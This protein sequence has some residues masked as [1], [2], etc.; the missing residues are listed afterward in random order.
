MDTEGTPT[1]PCFLPSPS[2]TCLCGL[3]V[4]LRDP[5]EPPRASQSVR[6]QVGK[7]VGGGSTAEASGH[8]PGLVSPPR[9]QATETPTRSPESAACLQPRSWL[10]LH[11]PAAL[12]P[13]G[14]GQ[15]TE[16]PE[17][18][19]SS[20]GVCAAFPGGL[21]SGLVVGGGGSSLSFSPHLALFLPGLWA[22]AAC[23]R[24]AFPL[25]AVRL[26]AS[27]AQP[28][29]CWSSHSHLPRPVYCL[30]YLPGQQFCL[31]RLP[32]PGDPAG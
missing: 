18:G 10:W 14:T 31:P 26:E 12:S 25:L 32:L 17:V 2:L 4:L 5:L 8:L 3:R 9:G 6:A 29:L 21:S 13:G 15:E 7:A 28:G 16:A 20:G 30:I 27:S 19:G 22:W 11:N 1:H 24:P 23:P